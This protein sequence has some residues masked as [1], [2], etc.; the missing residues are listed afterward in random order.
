MEDIFDEKHCGRAKNSH[1]NGDDE[2]RQRK[3]EITY[4]KV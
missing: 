1:G 2:E 3:A 4:K